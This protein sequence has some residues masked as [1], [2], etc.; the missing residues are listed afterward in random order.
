MLY[1]WAKRDVPAD[2]YPF[3]RF[4]VAADVVSYTDAEY[5]ALLSDDDRWTREMTDRLIEL[6]KSV[7]FLSRFYYDSLVV[8][9]AIVVAHS[10]AG[11]CCRPTRARAVV[12]F[13]SPPPPLPLERTPFGASPLLLFIAS[14]TTSFAG[15][16]V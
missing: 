13:L 15:Q 6:C 2:D 12:R 8:G 7:F 4:N 14:F 9:I 11:W 5:S 16:A 10:H 3:A 1:H